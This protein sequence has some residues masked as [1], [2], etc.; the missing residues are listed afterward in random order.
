MI[1]EIRDTFIQET[2]QNLS[3]IEE[4]LQMLRS[5]RIGQELMECIQ[6]T[7]HTIKGSGPMFG[8]NDLPE[9]ASPVERVVKQRILSARVLDRNEEVRLQNVI[10]L[11]KNKLT[12]LHSSA[13]EQEQE[14]QK[15]LIHFFN[16]LCQ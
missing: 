4:K 10:D 8:F 6:R 3:L 11:M 16:G 14:K 1:E 12:R 13:E 15:A 5:D 9:L 7:M 2:T